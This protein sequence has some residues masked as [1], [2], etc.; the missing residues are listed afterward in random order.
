MAAKK[1]HPV[2][3]QVDFA[4][5][6]T[7]KNR[8]GPQSRKFSPSVPNLGLKPKRS[9]SRINSKGPICSVHVP[10]CRKSGKINVLNKFS[11]GPSQEEQ[12]RKK[13]AHSIEGGRLTQEHVCQIRAV[14]MRWPS[15]AYLLIARMNRKKQ[16][17]QC[18]RNRPVRIHLFSTAAALRSCAIAAALRTCGTAITLPC[19]PR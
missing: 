10:T 17:S 12:G 6:T 4:F 3:T 19:S 14:A 7:E 1:V 13:T 5:G 11:F 18:E 2:N 8:S 9:F 16:Q 15:I